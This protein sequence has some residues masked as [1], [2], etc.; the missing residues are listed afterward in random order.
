MAKNDPAYRWGAEFG[1]KHG[2]DIINFFKNLPD[3]AV[4]WANAY[5]KHQAEEQRANAKVQ[6]K[7][8]KDIAQ[9]G[10]D[11]WDW[12]K[13][14]VQ[15]DIPDAADAFTT[16]LDQSNQSSNI[17]GPKTPRKKP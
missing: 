2:D 4:R 15:H 9:A 12:T 11:A 7:I 13:Q 3:D 16:G 8:G 6:R 14:T 17:A 5:A 10:S 1:Q